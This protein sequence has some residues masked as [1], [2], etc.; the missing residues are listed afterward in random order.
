MVKED[1]IP[2]D[3]D[4]GYDAAENGKVKSDIFGVNHATTHTP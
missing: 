4:T 3:S 2:D 1:V